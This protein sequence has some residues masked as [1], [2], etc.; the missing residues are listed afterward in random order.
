MRL[1]SHSVVGI[2]PLCAQFAAADRY[3]GNQN[4][5][6][7]DS[8]QIAANFPDIEGVEFFSPAFLHSDTIP[9]TWSNGTSGPT[10]Q[11]TLGMLHIF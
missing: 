6:V 4:P 9:S 1:I 7:I 8:P 2:L 11:S 5:V 10:P 3:A